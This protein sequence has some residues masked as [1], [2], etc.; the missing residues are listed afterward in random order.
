MIPELD[1]KEFSCMD[2][3][4]FNNGWGYNAPEPRE[5]EEECIDDENET[6]GTRED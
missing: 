3:S 4:P 6:D 5:E 1:P 2:D